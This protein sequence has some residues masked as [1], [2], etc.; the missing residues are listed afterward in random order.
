[1]GIFPIIMNILQFWLIDSIV[2][3]SAHS[4]SVALPSDSPRESINEDEEPLF[5]ASMDDEDDEPRPHDVE[6]PPPQPRSRSIS[7]DRRVSSIPDEPKSS[8]ASSTTA[9]GSGSLTPKAMDMGPEALAMH[10][11]PPSLGSTSTSSSR[12]SSSRGGSTSPRPQRSRRSPPP[13]L[14]FQ[15]RSP[16]P[17]AVK[18]YPEST[19]TSSPHHP[20]GNDQHD[21]KEWASWGDDNDWTDRGDGEDWTEQRLDI[22]KTS[23]PNAWANHELENSVRISSR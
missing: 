17:L 13:S 6:N 7:K 3:A 2:K 18:S 9:S 20:P 10:A 19:L 12:S 14:S 15:P 23:V 22:K 16:Q 11:Y 1:M 8:T 4:A 21:E 5:R